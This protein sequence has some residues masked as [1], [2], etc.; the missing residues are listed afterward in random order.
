MRPGRAAHVLLRGAGQVIFM[1]SARTGALFL[2]ALAWGAWAGGAPWAVVPGALL[3]LA[4]STVAAHLLGAPRA[5][6][7]SGLHGFNGLLVGAG[8]ATFVLPGPAM[9]LVLAL[10]AALSAAL[11]LALA[12]VLR[13][14]ALPG[15][16]LPFIACTWLVLLAARQWPAL[17]LADAPAPLLPAAPGEALA[18]V[19]ALLA[20]VAQIF[21]VN[22]A[23][24]G[25]LIV[26]A[27]ALHSRPAAL[28]TLAGAATGVACA[29]AL[30]AE[31]AA[32]AQGLWG[33]SAALT[34]PAVGCIFQPPGRRSLALALGAT[35]LA[36]LL[37]GAIATLVQPWGLPPLTLAFVLATW[38]FLLLRG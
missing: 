11:A 18:L 3:G 28:L 35:L 9:W 23:L 19:R 38:V 1:D 29:L 10:A 37:Q 13:G 2:A 7:D 22:D 31:R 16:T 14:W 32:L 4:A 27:L 15:L 20:S 12:R 6:L 17:A 30:G 33:Y 8:V 25:A 5:A 26:L 36:V 34:A 24:A 21:F